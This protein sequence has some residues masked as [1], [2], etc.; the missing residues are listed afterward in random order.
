[1]VARTVSGVVPSVRRF[2]STQ[3]YASLSLLSMIDTIERL[4]GV[5]G[6]LQP[7]RHGTPSSRSTDLSFLTMCALKR[8]TL[9]LVS[10]LI[11]STSKGRILCL[12]NDAQVE[13]CR[14]PYTTGKKPIEGSLR[15]V[16]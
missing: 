11:Q 14:M 3:S 6:L 2:I 9:P 8:G 15:G 13:W 12:V 10:P 7:L 4:A 5:S 1:M 16:V